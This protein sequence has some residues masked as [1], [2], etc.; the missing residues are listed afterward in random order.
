[1]LRTLILVLSLVGLTGSVPAPPQSITALA[2]VDVVAGGFGALRG[3]VV[4]SADRLYVADRESGTVTRIG[5]DGTR[6]LAR[7]LEQPVGLALDLQGRLL[8]A[9]ER[10]GRVVRLDPDGPTPIVQ[11]VKQPRW[12]AVSERG[13]VYVS[14]RR[15]TRDTDPEPDDESAEPEMILALTGDGALSVFADGFDHLQ[16]LASHD[17]AVYAATTGPRGVPRQ[18]GVLYRIPVLPDGGA[19]RPSRLGP[20]DVYERPTGL[21]VDRLGAL[22][23]S[24]TAT[25]LDGPRSPH[26]LLKVRPDGAATAF[27]T[28]LDDPRGLAFDS[29][30]HL[31]VADG[32]A[33][34]VL[35]FLAPAAPILAGVPSFTN[36]ASVTLTGTTAPNARV[37]AFADD[38][39]LPLTAVASATGSFALAV[40]PISNAVNGFDVFATAR[41]G[42]GLTSPPD[43]VDFVHDTLAPALVVQSPPAGTFV[44]G[45]IEMRADAAD[46]GSLLATLGLGAAGQALGAAVVPPLP[47][48]AVVATASWRTR[49]VPDGTQTLTVSATDR[50]GNAA[51]VSRVVIVDNTPP[52]TE[53]SGGPSGPLAEPSATFTFTGSDNLSPAASLRFAW[54]L[55]GGPL[56]PFADATSLTL[57]DLAPGPHLVEVVARDQAGNE[58]P[59]PAQRT[60]SVR[61]ATITVAIAAPGAGTTVPAGLLLVRGTADGGGVDVTVDVNGVAALVHDVQWAA[62]VPVGP[63]N[64]L[65]TVTAR[66]TAGA[67]ATASV[68]VTGT[69]AAP[70]LF[71][72]AEPRSG[73]APLQVTWRVA[74]GT[75]HPLVQF[76]LDAHGDGTYGPATAVLDG[77]QSTYATAGLWLP[78]VRATDDQGNV[79]VATTLVQ[80]GDAQTA[81]G[82]FQALWA[83]FKARLQAGDQPGA[84]AHLSSSLRSRFEPI[85]QQLG[86]ALPGIAASLGAVELIDQ[87]D[88]LAE[89]AILQAEDGTTRLYFVYFRRD[90]RG[91]WL[92][93]EM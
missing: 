25:I 36:Q 64:N 34:R 61:A 46:A 1:M 35:R 68:V 58:D 3:I 45:T 81:A 85:F 87:V 42:R 62:Q 90:N 13:T 10:A 73:V 44:R 67:E 57:G 54:R 49:D 41:R 15:L 55:D 77:T 51:T 18:G 78:T 20:R 26:A 28:G 59:T 5:D 56:S 69:A 66:T 31:Y 52:E 82:R 79:H 37:D 19:G 84:L 40:T 80:V 39:D 63:G 8:V 72:R 91:Q 71:V 7:R 48:P 11:G 65:I 75:P 30:G 74:N 29:H 76:E 33:G 2:P 12:L 70:G 92:I 53:I 21:A 23:V 60:F 50:A 86:A 4:D 17:G 32:N 38:G 43:A 6:V 83:N 16:G 24:A 14:A 22:Y 27:A 88:D 47:A 93:Q 9:E 89:A